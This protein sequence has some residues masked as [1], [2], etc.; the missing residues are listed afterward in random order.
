MHLWIVEMKLK[1][2]KDYLPGTGLMFNEQNIFFNRRAARRKDT[3]LT[4]LYGAKNV[5][6]RVRKYEREE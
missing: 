6:F 5:K 1:D 4:N 3:K 2:M